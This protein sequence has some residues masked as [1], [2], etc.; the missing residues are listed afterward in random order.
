MNIIRLTTRIYPDKAGPARYAYLLPMHISDKEHNIFNIT[1]KPKKVNENFK[2]INPHY[3]IY[4]LPIKTPSLGTDESFFGFGKF[5][6]K[7]G[8]LASK[9]ILEIHNKYGVDIIHCDNPS[10]TGIV[11]WM[12]NRVF[13]IPYIY[14]HHGLD[15]HFALNT[16]IEMSV[17]YKN[18]AKHIIISRQYRDFFEK[19]EVSTDKLVWIPNGVEL[20]KF[21]H[22]NND[23]EK[24][25]LIK[26]LKIDS[27]I[28]SGDFIIVYIAYMNKDLKTRGIIDFLHALK[29]FLKSLTKSE[30]K[31]IKVLFL[32]D[33][34]DKTLIKDEIYKLKLSENAF[35]LGSRRGIEKFYAIADLCALT[36]H[37]EGFPTVLLEATA[38]KICC[39]STDV[40]E[41]KSILDKRALVPPKNREKISKKLKELYENKSLRK[42]I[43]EKSYRKIQQFDWSNIANQIKEL[44]ED[45]LRNRDN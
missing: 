29:R 15:S 27:L 34:K 4:Y 18:S 19:S 36:S 41:V 33:G 30:Q 45:I 23:N 14:T 21:F 9:K 24:H 26:D 12:F 22:V 10:I 11:A 37:M 43:M 20:N 25:I 13:K 32:G 3:R 1:C 17:I 16:K 39:L 44:Y 42:E 6:V 28:N 31:T 35:L 38:S 5:F 7:F 40:G 2:L 8:L